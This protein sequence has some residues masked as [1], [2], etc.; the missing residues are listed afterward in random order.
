MKKIIKRKINSLYI[1]IP[2]CEKICP[3]CDFTKV[4]AN[5]DSENK[6]IQEILKD[7]DYFYQNKVK[8]KTIYIGGGTPSILNCA[9]LENLL[10]K[11]SKLLKF[12][13]EFTVELNPESITKSKLKLLKKYEVNRISI[14]IQSFNSKILEQ[15]DR[16]YSINY[17]DLIALARKYFKNINVD[18]IYGFH[19][20]TF[21]DF[22]DD[23]DQ[24]L[25]LKIDHIS[26]YSLSINKGTLFYN[27]KY[28]E[29]EDDYSRELYDY[30]LQKLRENGF[31]RYEVSNF[32][33]NSKKS[34]HNL[35][36]WQNDFYYGIG[37]GSHGYV[38]NIRYNISANLRKYLN[39]ERSIEKE[40][41]DHNAL[42]EY[43]LITNLRLSKG[44]SLKKYKKIFNEDFLATHQEAIKYLKNNH[45][46]EYNKH[47][48]RCTDEG[49]M[50]LNQVLLRLL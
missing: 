31:E 10:V 26:A 49:I 35:T 34:K 32:A 9:N 22:K 4:L 8:F 44:F 46:I 18:L 38:D 21:E 28:K 41:V 15:I 42:K 2:F 24:F 23:I 6:Y 50:L 3:Y 19:D 17:Y 30:M 40:V 29:V 20:Q 13:G 16:S 48:F 27:H 5:S 39:G 14:G 43:F 37:I 33:R 47:Y 12:G 1:H 7:L 11:T 25:K 36:Y 45:L